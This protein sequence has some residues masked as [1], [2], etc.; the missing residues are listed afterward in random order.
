MFDGIVYGLFALVVI[1]T[2]K[3]VNFFEIEIELALIAFVGFFVFAIF[4]IQYIFT[5]A[6]RMPDKEMA[7]RMVSC[8]ENILSTRGSRDSICFQ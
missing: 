2:S 4:G 6:N 7:K 1:L 5:V 8:S 3:F